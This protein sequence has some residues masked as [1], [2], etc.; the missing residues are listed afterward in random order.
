MGRLNNLNDPVLNVLTLHIDGNYCQISNAVKCEVGKNKVLVSLK[1][2]SICQYN[3]LFTLKH[4]K[5]RSYVY[6]LSVSTINAAKHIHGFK[7]CKSVY[8]RTI[9][10]NHQPV[11]TIFQFIIL[12]FIYSPSSGA[13][14]LQW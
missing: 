10:I 7:V 14:L 2:L 4:H 8:H 13:Q 3:T 6:I 12:T 11:A 9:Q 1:S 5:N